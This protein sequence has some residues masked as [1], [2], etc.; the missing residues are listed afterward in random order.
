MSKD[1]IFEL[2]L[3]LNKPQKESCERQATI[4][5]PIS[6]IPLFNLS[7]LILLQSKTIS[8]WRRLLLRAGVTHRASAQKST[9]KTLPAEPWHFWHH[10]QAKLF[11][12]PEIAFRNGS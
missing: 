5:E 10:Q 8:G 2:A 12:A 7:L 11:G 4:L 6:Y 9:A 3:A 1:H